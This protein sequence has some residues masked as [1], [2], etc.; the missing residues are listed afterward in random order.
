MPLFKIEGD[1]LERIEQ[2]DF[3]LE[4]DIQILTEN[5]LKEI[6]HLDFVS[7]EFALQDL[8]IDT[9]GFD[10]ETKSFV[11][12]EYKKD[13]N[14]GVVDQGYA[15][16]ALLLNNQADFIL[17]YNEKM[18][19]NLRKGDVDWEQSKVIFI[20]P[21]FTTYQRKSIEFKDLPFE[22]WEIVK[23]NNDT[24]LFNYLKPPK[25]K[26][27]INT[28]AKKDKAVQYVN[29]KIK[30]YN[31]EDH[32]ETAPEEIK[33][34]Y[35]NIRERIVNLGP[36]I[37]VRPTKLY[38][39]FVDN[40]NFIYAFIFKK[41]VKLVL[42]MKKGELKDPE[43]I[44]KD[45]SSIGHQ[46]YGDYRVTITPQDDIDYLMTLIKQPYKKQTES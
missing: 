19:K 46:G 16:L 24:L 39:A 14:S 20:S 45:I 30:T 4:K 26:V 11:I 2:V 34:L 35:E 42:N 15:Y 3:K 27:S 12:I 18:D 22:L 33:E 6:F 40:S 5:N 37:E 29:K 25:T 32:L 1:K 23:Y 36:E 10:N 13:R 21:R 43:N 9:L 17:E 38:I 31:E 8:R 28:V 41:H 44:A 7:T